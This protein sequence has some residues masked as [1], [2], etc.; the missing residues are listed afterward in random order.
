MN[1]A[2]VIVSYQGKDWLGKCLESCRLHAAEV[3]VYVVDNAST[4]SSAEVAAQFAGVTVL[5]QEVN[6][7]FAAGNNVGLRTAMHDGAEAVLLLNQDA[8]LT[9]G[10]LEALIA[11]LIAHAKVAGV[12]PAILLPSG[13]VNSLGNSF[14]YLGFG[15]AGGNGLSLAEATARL[16]WLRPGGEPPYLS[17]A[18]VLLRAEALRQGGLFQDELFMYHEDLELSLRLRAAGWHLAV[19]PQAQALHHYEPRRSLRQYYYMERNRLMVWSEIFSWPTL[20]VLLP[21]LVLAEVGLLVPAIAQGWLGAKLRAY[22]YFLKPGTW[23][24]IHQHRQTV[25]KLKRV[26]DAELLA[27]ASSRVEYQPSM[28]LLTRLVF[29]PLSSLGWAVLKPLIRW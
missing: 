9:S 17:G 29:N 4:D 1:T 11:H 26:R 3:P 23:L 14:H 7:G 5:R 10:C 12:Q 20:L 25:C 28:G 18:A 2:I 19:A 13:R 27:Y 22:L 21:A 24:T 8:E 15:E 16:P 6:L